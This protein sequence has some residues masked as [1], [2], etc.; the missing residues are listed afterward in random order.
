MKKPLK[1]PVGHADADADQ[2]PQR[3]CLEPLSGMLGGEH[4]VDQRD[5]GAGRQVE[6]ADQNDERLAHAAAIASVA[7]PSDRKLSSK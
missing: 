5:D 1:A 3:R 4:D 6:A 2:R 7:P